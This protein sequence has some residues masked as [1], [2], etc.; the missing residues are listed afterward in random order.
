M[1]AE[2]P[3]EI[4][5]ALRRIPWFQRLQ[6]RHFAALAAIATLRRAEGG[7]VL[8]REGDPQDFLYVL[9]EGRVALEMHVPGRERVRL[10]TAEP[11][12]VVGWSSVVP[13]VRWRTASAVAVLPSLLVALDAPAM[14]RLCEEDHDLGYIVMRRLA[15]VVA[16]R[17]MVTRLQL[18]DIYAHPG[19]EGCD[20]G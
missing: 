2:I 18:L 17:L 4:T 14:L 3:P 16:Q 8:F 11:M 12:D 19:T 1:C 20:D 6:P 13:R 7:E 9:L 15:N 10:M 5:S